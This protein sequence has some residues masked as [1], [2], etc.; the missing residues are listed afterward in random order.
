MILKTQAPR[1]C[2]QFWRLSRAHR[3]RPGYRC[4]FY[5]LPG[6]KVQQ[7][8]LPSRCDL[9][10]CNKWRTPILLMYIFLFIGLNICMYCYCYRDFNTSTI[11]LL[12]C[13]LTR[14]SERRQLVQLWRRWQTALA[15]PHGHYV[16]TECLDRSDWR[17][18]QTLP[19]QGCWRRFLLLHRPRTQDLRRRN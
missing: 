8:C 9:R 18:N 13:G 7:Q 16:C 4:S 19:S 17:H 3:R 12:L 11:V 14:Y 10:S 5:L 15:N 2:K 1:V 6:N